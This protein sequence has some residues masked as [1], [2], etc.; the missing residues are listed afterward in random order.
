MIKSYL[1]TGIIFVLFIAIG[2][3]VL[4]IRGK[5]NKRLKQ[6]MEYKRKK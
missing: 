1:W 6:M 2:L 3:L 5:E 4:V